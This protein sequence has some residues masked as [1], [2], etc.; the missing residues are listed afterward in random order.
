MYAVINEALKAFSRWEELNKRLEDV[1]ARKDAADKQLATLDAT[2]IDA[3]KK[4]KE[5]YAEYNRLQD[6]L[7][8]IQPGFA[9]FIRN[10]PVL[11]LA[12]PS[13]KINQVMPANLQDDVIF[14]GTPKVDRC[15]TCHL[16]IDKKGFENQPQPFTTH[17]NLA[18]YLQGPHP[19]D[20]VGCTSCHQGRGRATSFMNA[21]HIPATAQQE[22][23]T[24]DACSL[25]TKEEVSEVQG[26][27]ITA[28]KSSERGDE[29]VRTSQCYYSATE[30]SKSVNIGVTRSRTGERVKE[31]WG[32]M[33]GEGAE[34]RRSNGEDVAY[35][36]LRRLRR[37]LP[38]AGE[39]WDS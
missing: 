37:H 25:L 33:F 11:D 27:P 22:T 23:I 35:L 2:R 17:P 9:T 16:G 15:T 13:L 10:M 1:N 20:K 3:E 7:S 14:S 36:L 32:S 39:D 8:K 18:F 19:I 24:F 34:A 38:L 5:L 26:S 6:R 30:S 4:R 21:V 31:M 28:T 29:S 12:N